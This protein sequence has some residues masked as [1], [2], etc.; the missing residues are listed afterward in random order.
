MKKVAIL[1][2]VWVCAGGAW[3]ARHLI[4]ADGNIDAVVFDNDVRG[5]GADRGASGNDVFD[6]AA[7]GRIDVGG[8]EP[9]RPTDQ[10]TDFDVVAYLHGGRCR[11]TDVLR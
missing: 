2:M 6:F 7:D 1:V 4:K 5:L 8:N 9:R 3:G 10:C 11:R